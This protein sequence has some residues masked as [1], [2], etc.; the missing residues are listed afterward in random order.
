MFHKKNIF[1]YI[2]ENNKGNNGEQTNKI[3]FY[4]KKINKIQSDEQNFNQNFPQN[5]N[6]QINSTKNFQQN[7]NSNG[8]FFF[9]NNNNNN[10]KNINKNAHFKKK[11]ENPYQSQTNQSFSYFNNILPQ[12]AGTINFNLIYC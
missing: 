12:Q 1:N 9:K 8:N 4:N 3:G 2:K 11:N 7:N 10:K 5:M 6:I